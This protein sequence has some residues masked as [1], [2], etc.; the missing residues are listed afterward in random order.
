[1]LFH[2]SPGL[3]NVNLEIQ[4]N[5]H[6]KINSV[7][8]F[9]VNDS[10]MLILKSASTYENNARLYIQDNGELRFR[11]AAAL[12]INKYGSVIVEA[13]GKL[14]MENHS[15]ITFR[16]YSE[17]RI[18]QGGLFCNEGARIKG[19]ANIIYE[20]GSIH[21][22]MCSSLA[23][24]VIS[25]SAKVILDSNAV[26]EIPD[27]TTISF[28]GNRT[29]LVMHPNSVIRF[30]ANSKLLFDS[31]ATF[32]A[33]N[34][35]FTSLDTFG[36][37]EG[38]VLQNTGEDSV[39]NC[40]FS[41]A[42]TSLALIN[43]PGHTF[44]SRVI[45]GNVFNVP[46]GGVESNG[47]YGENN[48]RITVQDN[49]FN[50]P[51]NQ[52]NRIFGV[53][54]KNNNTTGVESLPDVNEGPAIPFSMFLINNTFY[55]GTASALLLNYTSSYLPFYVKGN[56]FNSASTAGIIGRNI[57]GS[58]KDNVFSNSGSIIPMGIHLIASS[59]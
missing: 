49:V 22:I 51:A 56:T 59:P 33:K 38:I 13:G 43:T 23:D 48:F 10:A 26:L 20:G 14:V 41:N 15:Y 52:S 6:A 17:I 34:A 29:G 36:K 31:S 25:D 19:N 7:N 9:I 16:P 55:N 5:H 39:I 40:T 53:Y 8:P 3:L 11:N 28:Y 47:I 50:M 1:M 35:T 27:S 30:G 44:Y 4:N 24:F 32:I 42:K 21:H 12:V 54:L 37:W 18:K 58:I 2:N 57:T 45:K 46:S